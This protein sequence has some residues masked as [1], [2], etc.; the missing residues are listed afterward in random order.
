MRTHGTRSRIMG[1]SPPVRALL[2][3]TRRPPRLRAAGAPAAHV[4]HSLALGV[5]Q[6][7][8]APTGP[9][10]SAPARACRTD[11]PP[12]APKRTRTSTRS[13]RTRPS[14]PYTLSRRVVNRP[15]RSVVSTV[16]NNLDALE[17][18]DV[19]MGV[20]AIRDQGGLFSGCSPAIRDVVTRARAWTSRAR[21]GSPAAVVLNS[22]PKKIWAHSPAVVSPLLHARGRGIG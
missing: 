2:I 18:V 14:S 8:R 13:S 15:V 6:R 3:V 12:G 5:A 21:L 7:A 17:K 11:R 16:E 9:W 19:A 22:P 20:A 4:H 10:R 1:A